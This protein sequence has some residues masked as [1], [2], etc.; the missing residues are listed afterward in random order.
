MRLISCT[1][2]FL[3]ALCVLAG[4]VSNTWARDY[5]PRFMR[6]YPPGYYGM[7][8]Y[9]SNVCLRRAIGGTGT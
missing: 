7:W 3:I 5:D 1:T 2:V 8:Y 6:N 4:T 9:A